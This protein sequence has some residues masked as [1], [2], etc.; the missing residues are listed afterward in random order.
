[1]NVMVIVSVRSEPVIES[2][3]E[4]AEMTTRE[5]IQARKATGIAVTS[6]SNDAPMASTKVIFK[7]CL[8]LLRFPQ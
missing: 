2:R 7:V 3:L 6:K 8:S 1:M 5:A 4:S